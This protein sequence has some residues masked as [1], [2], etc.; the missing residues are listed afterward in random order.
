MARTLA[1]ID[2]AHVVLPDI[3]DILKSDEKDLLQK[4]RHLTTP[5]Q[6]LDANVHREAEVPYRKE[7]DVTRLPE[8]LRT[9]EIKEGSSTAWKYV[10]G[11]SLCTLL[12]TVG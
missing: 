7:T 6:P 9:R 12:L 2:K 10:L 8:E 3:E 4:Q 11:L 1:G 5:L